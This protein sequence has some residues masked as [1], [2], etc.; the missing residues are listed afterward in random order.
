MITSFSFLGELSLQLNNQS[1]AGLIVFSVMQCN[2]PA[3]V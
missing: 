3:Y 1:P 2:D